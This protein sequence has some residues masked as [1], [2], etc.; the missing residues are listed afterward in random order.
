[1]EYRPRRITVCGSKSKVKVSHRHRVNKCIFHTTVRSITQKRMIPVFKHGVG[2]DIGISYKWLSQRGSLGLGLTAGRHGFELYEF[3]LVI[4]YV[5][6]SHVSLST[7]KSW[8]H[9]CV[10]LRKVVVYKLTQ[11]CMVARSILEAEKV[12]KTRGALDRG[13]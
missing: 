13:A 9:H 10:K 5:W 4:Y 11:I 6:K 1:M 8:L 7:S 12:Q 3:L 2:N